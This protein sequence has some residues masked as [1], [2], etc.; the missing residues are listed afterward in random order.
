MSETVQAHPLSPTSTQLV[1]LHIEGMHCGHCTQTIKKLL[2]E[3]GACDLTIDINTSSA[4]L[5]PGRSTIT[6][7]LRRLN[8]AGYPSRL[9]HEAPIEQGFRFTIER[10][11]LVSAVFTVPLMAHMV[12]SHPLFHNHLFQALMAVPVT[13]IGI[14]H[15]GGS[16]WKA[17]RQGVANMDLLIFI[18]IVSAFS[19]SLYGTL[20]GLGDNFLFYETA[21]SITFFVLLGNFMERRSM[22]KTSAAVE[23]LARLQPESATRIA[24]D[25]QFQNIRVA[26]VTAGDLLLVRSGEKVPVDGVITEGHALINESFVSGESL[27]AERQTGDRVIGGS[28]V[29]QG[30]VRFTASAVGEETV[31]SQIIRLVKTATSQKP[32]I[33]QLGDKVSSIFVPVVLAISILTFAIGFFIG[34]LSFE[35]SLLQAIAV[36]VI[37]CPCAMGLATPTAVTVGIGRAARSGA[38]IKGG[39]VLERLAHIDTILFD[40]TGTLTD[41]ALALDQIEV[42]QGDREE[43]L[44]IIK[45]ME[46]HSTHPLAQTIVRA[47][48]DT[49]TIPLADIEEQRGRGM[50]A[51]GSQETRYILGSALHTGVSNRPGDIFLT[52]N[53]SL[54]AVITIRDCIKP[55]AREVVRALQARRKRLVIISGDHQEKVARVAAELGIREFHAAQLPDQKLQLTR[56]LSQGGNTC[57]IGDGINDAPALAQA[58]VGISLSGAT[59]VAIQTAEVILLDGKLHQLPALLDLSR[60]T[61][62]TIKENLFW[63]FFYNSLAIPLAAFGFLT[64]LVAA[65]TMAFSDVIVIGNSLRL[66]VRIL[67]PE[68][69]D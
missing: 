35:Q 53:G 16:A 33:Q 46:L 30:M 45:S 38:L 28:I 54:K 63:A 13:A 67:R 15:F 47:L 1:E 56:E 22:K 4:L 57:F 31:L 24:E 51:T 66:K 40:K 39:A 7:I 64:P 27:P 8:K 10:K 43:A 62:K 52:A 36:L 34:G 9:M 42:I 55:E 14:L 49:D 2:T 32:A 6:S 59:Q 12:L 19:Y 48:P 50:S 3:A 18:G 61:F 37:S 25:G 29:Q 41:G 11:L 58:S 65:L 26:E 69:H 20:A 44:K 21:A 17:L 60:L 68:S 5:N 23:E